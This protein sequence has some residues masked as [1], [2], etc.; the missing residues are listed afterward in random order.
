MEN[1]I[2][3]RLDENTNSHILDYSNIQ[4]VFDER[5]GKDI[6]S[7]G[8]IRFRLFYKKSLDPLELVLAVCRISRCY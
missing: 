4:I 1:N 3:Y 2:T 7:E 8:G 5:D 6:G